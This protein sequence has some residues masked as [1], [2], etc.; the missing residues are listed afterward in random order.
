M[1]RLDKHHLYVTNVVLVERP[2]AIAEIELPHSNKVVV[3]TQGP[4][5]VDSL[6][7]CRAPSP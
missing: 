7:E 5:L 3:E 6:G 1:K 4:N 2:L